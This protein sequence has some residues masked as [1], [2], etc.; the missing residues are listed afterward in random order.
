MKE[1]G[2]GAMECRWG[3]LMLGNGSPPVCK[4][5]VAC[6]LAQQCWDLFGGY[7]KEEK[8]SMGKLAEMAVL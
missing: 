5:L 3:G 7:V 2:A 8:V 4:H 6:Y 1:E